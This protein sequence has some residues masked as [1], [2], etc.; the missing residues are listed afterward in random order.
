MKQSYSDAFPIIGL[1]LWSVYGRCKDMN[2]GKM[3][4]NIYFYILHIP[5][6]FCENVATEEQIFRVEP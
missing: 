5:P 1:A 2:F 3:M 4:E 6:T